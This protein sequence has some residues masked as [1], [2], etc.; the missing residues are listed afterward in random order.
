MK[1]SMII[2]VTVLTIFCGIM[3][4]MLLKTPASNN[5]HSRA[6]IRLPKMPKSLSP[7]RPPFIKQNSKDLFFIDHTWSIYKQMTPVRRDIDQFLSKSF[8]HLNKNQPSKS[9][10]KPPIIRLQ[11]KPDGRVVV[12][13]TAKHTKWPVAIKPAKHINQKNISKHKP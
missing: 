7:L 2:A 1:N 3:A 6:Q 4:Y 11:K 5:G 10:R 12:V 9:F 13:N 8:A